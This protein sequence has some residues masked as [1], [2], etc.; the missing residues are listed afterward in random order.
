[1]ISISV[2]IFPIWCRGY[3]RLPFLCRCHQDVRIYSQALAEAALT[4]LG[5]RALYTYDAL[6]R[7]VAKQ[8]GATTTT[9]VLGGA[10]VLE[11]YV[12]GGYERAYVNKTIAMV[13]AEETLS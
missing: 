3:D 13:T 8:V 4:A 11:E 7:R 5:T 2:T 9:Y 12:E 6:G 10:Q 1:M